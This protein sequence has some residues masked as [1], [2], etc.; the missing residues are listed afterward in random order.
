VN[1]PAGVTAVLCAAVLTVVSHIYVTIPVIPAVAEDL[2]TTTSAAA[3]AGSVFGVTFALG[4]LVFPTVSDHVDPRRVMAVGLVLVAVADVVAGL[5]TELGVLVGA[6]AAQGF[7]APALPPVALAYLPRVVPGRVAP[8]ALAVLSSTFLLA[9]IVGQGWSLLLHPLLGWRW[10]MW[11]VVP[12]L[13][14]LAALVVRL[15]VA[16]RPTT[17]MS[18][19]GV[20]RTLSGLVRRRQVVVAYAAALTVLTSLVGMY[21]ALEAASAELGATSSA[22]GLL[23]RLPGVPGIVLGCFAGTAV[24]RW[25][26]HAT[27]AGAFLVAAG[28]LVV[29]AVAGPL[30]LTLAGSAVFVAGLAVAVPAV[31]ALVGAASRPARGAGMAGYAFFVGL[32]ACLGPLVADGLAGSDLTVT[33]TLLAGVLLVPAVSLALTRGPRP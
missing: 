25:G 8:T 19:A 7:L 33:C 14:V 26:P 20:A 32:G 2:G 28:G 30:W 27:G 17:P 13:L 11:G 18:L 16:P 15:P 12:L 6:R 3:W 29:E 31:V 10:V 5:A 22:T 9:G 1:R 21:V 24:R 23:L 4:A